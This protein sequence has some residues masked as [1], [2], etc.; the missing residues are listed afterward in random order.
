MITKI[1]SFQD[2]WVVKGILA[3]TALSF[4]SLFGISGYI[5]RSGNNRPIV[6][7]D[8]VVVTQE[9]INNQLNEQIRATKNMFGEDMEISET[10]RAAMLQDIVQKDLVNAIMQKT[11]EDNSVDISDELIRKI[12]YS[13]PEFMDESG[14]FNLDKMRRMLSMT[15]WSEQKYID[16]L[17]RD[18]IKQHLV[19]TPVEGIDVPK[20]IDPYLAELDSQRKVFQFAVIEPA[21]LKVDRKAS[22]EEIEQYYQDFA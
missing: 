8:D 22:Q 2:S 3:L 20:L 7:V 5:S 19:Q 21:K 9:E 12:I 4:M 14:Q 6:R 17:R 11:A 15:G 13:Q 10:M 18:I 1:R 16:T